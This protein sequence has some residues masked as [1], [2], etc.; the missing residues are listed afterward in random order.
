[1]DKSFR[2]LLAGAMFLAG[3]LTVP[4]FCAAQSPSTNEAASASHAPARAATPQGQEGAVQLLK[5]QIELEENQIEQLQGSLAKQQRQLDQLTA[6]GK[7]ASA[8]SAV[9]NPAETAVQASQAKPAMQSSQPLIATT[10]QPPLAAESLPSENGSSGLQSEHNPAIPN[11]PIP[12]E[13]L[14]IGNATLTPVGFVDATAFFRSR[15]LG[16]G[17][18]ASF[19]SLPF[20]NTVPGH[21][22]ETR[23][24]IQNSRFGL[25]YDSQFDHNKVR[26]YM[27]TDFLGAQPANAFVTSNSDS[28]RVRLYWVD[29]TRGKFE[30]LAGQSWSLLTPGR[31]G[32]SPMPSDLFYTQDMDTNYQVGLTWSRQLQ[33]RFVYH[34][35]PAVTAALSLE[36]AE[37]YVGG[38]VSLHSGFSSGEVSTGSATSTPNVFPDVIGKLAFDPTVGGKHMHIEFAGLL[39]TFKTYNATT[40]TSS[41][42]EGGGGSFNFNLELFKNFHLVESS[43]YSSGGGRYLYGLGPDFIVRPDGS[44]SLVHAESGIGGFEYQ[45]TPKTMFYGYYGGAYYGRNYSVIPSGSGGPPSYVGYGYTGSP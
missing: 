23:L 8:P 33:F 26:G 34:A 20:S 36:N 11:S 16:S 40:N 21:M 22:A 42:V 6:R 43:F 37:Q 41:S 24:T 39:S 32:I 12:A 28:L 13:P 19:G 44:P 1:M 9:S 10:G 2:G 4:G 3:T 45:I 27:E 15:N 5:K 38:A 35:S 25:Q 29:L 14:K 30:F 7:T 17:I 31:N 18:G